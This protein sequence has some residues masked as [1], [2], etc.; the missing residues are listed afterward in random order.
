[1]KKSAQSKP[2]ASAKRKEPVRDISADGLVEMRGNKI[3]LHEPL[4]S[5]VAEI[6][7]HRRISLQQ[8]WD[9]AVFDKLHDIAVKIKR[10]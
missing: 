10:P 9:D 3:V 7:K 2:L 6:C 5:E 1:M 4:A 8:F